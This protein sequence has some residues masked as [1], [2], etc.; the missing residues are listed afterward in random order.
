MIHVTI[1]ALNDVI[2]VA[3]VGLVVGMEPDVTRTLVAIWHRKF[4]DMTITS[5]IRDLFRVLLRL[6]GGQ[7][8]GGLCDRLLPTLMTAVNST[9]ENSPIVAV[10]PTALSIIQEFI[11]AVKIIGEGGE[12]GK[13]KEERGTGRDHPMLKLVFPCVIGAIE[14]ATDNS[15]IVEAASDALAC[16]VDVAGVEFTGL[17]LVFGFLV[18]EFY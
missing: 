12:E 14:R 3:D 5:D 7:C 17:V 11:Q 15:S 18:F 4:G 8:L 2:R 6:G 1:L 10:V 16:L 13:G 9:G